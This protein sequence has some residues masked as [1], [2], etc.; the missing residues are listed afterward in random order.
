MAQVGR[1]APLAPR[2]F[3]HVGTEMADRLAK[4]GGAVDRQFGIA[5]QGIDIGAV[6]RA[7][8]DTEAGLLG[9]HLAI[10]RE[11]RDKAP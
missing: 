9:Q 8:R 11:R 4:A 10:E 5:E 2:H 3:V 7:H 1:D 6:G